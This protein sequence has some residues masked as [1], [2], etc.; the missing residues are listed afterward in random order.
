M[1]P[2]TPMASVTT[3]ATVERGSKVGEITNP[4]SSTE[5]PTAYCERSHLQSSLCPHPVFL[6]HQDIPPDPPK[7]FLEFAI[8]Y[9]RSEWIT[10][11]VLFVQA[12]QC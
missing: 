10:V 6:Q 9:P 1:L 8:P 7:V 12:M 5:T 2:V 3:P 11:D 4:I